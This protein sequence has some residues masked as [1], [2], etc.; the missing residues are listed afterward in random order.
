MD[1]VLTELEN[2]DIHYATVTAVLGRGRQKGES[3]VYRSHKEVGNLLKKT[4]L[5]IVLPKEQVQIALSAIAKGARTGNVGDGKI[6]VLDAE[7][8]VRIRTAEKTW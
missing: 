8:C 4:K 5:E 2:N 1:D 7:H 6:F 3:A